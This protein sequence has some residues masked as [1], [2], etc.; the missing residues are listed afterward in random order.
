MLTI[1]ISTDKQ[2]RFTAKRTFFVDGTLLNAP[3]PTNF[4]KTLDTKVVVRRGSI[5]RLLSGSSSDNYTSASGP[6]DWVD[7][8][9]IKDGSC[10]ACSS[11]VPLTNPVK[12]QVRFAADIVELDNATGYL[13]VIRGLQNDARSAHTRRTSHDLVMGWQDWK[14]TL[15][16]TSKHAFVNAI[17]IQQEA[18]SNF[19]DRSRKW[20]TSSEDA[21]RQIGVCGSHISL[22]PTTETM[23][24]FD[25]CQSKHSSRLSISAD[26]QE[27]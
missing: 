24:G 10:L 21:R 7:T 23:I 25:H 15:H 4:N 13:E 3:M 22:L 26:N 20:T 9:A 16:I 19:F 6:K 8:D 14:E 27:D 1:G 5:T 12:Q 17:R 11:Y 18:N 2:P